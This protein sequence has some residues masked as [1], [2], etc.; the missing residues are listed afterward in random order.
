VGAG[1]RLGAAVLG[2]GEGSGEGAGVVG[3][4]D[5]SGVTLGEA[6]GLRS[7]AQSVVRQKE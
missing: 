1:V 2:S 4:S 5:G 7:K 3:S 6:V